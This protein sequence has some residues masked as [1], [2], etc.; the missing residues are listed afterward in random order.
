MIPVA[1]SSKRM[2]ESVRA[3]RAVAE[4]S[5]SSVRRMSSV[6]ERMSRMIE[7]GL[8]SSELGLSEH[9]LPSADQRHRPLQIGELQA[10]LRPQPG[11]ILDLDGIVASQARDAIDGLRREADI[12]AVDLESVD[13][14]GKEIRSPPGLRA[15]QLDVEH[16]QGVDNIGCVADE[17][18]CLLIGTEAGDDGDKR[19]EQ[20]R[21]TRRNAEK[22][23]SVE[24]A[25]TEL[26]VDR[27]GQEERCGQQGVAA[28]RGVGK[29]KRFRLR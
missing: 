7:L 16:R 22:R 1:A 15:L 24:A 11:Y 4:R 25:V 10:H 12:V 14:G 21:E 26:K 3:D 27:H 23:Q 8:A 29:A 19:R 20:E 18:T 13:V 28:P 9:R 17:L 5:E 6:I 2:V